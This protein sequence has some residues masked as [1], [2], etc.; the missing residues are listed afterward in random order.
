MR[1]WKKWTLK[2]RLA[3]LTILKEPES[4]GLASIPLLP[5]PSSPKKEHH[6]YVF[7]FTC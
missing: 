2:M 7:P 6:S 3:C 1:Y 4:G 5:L